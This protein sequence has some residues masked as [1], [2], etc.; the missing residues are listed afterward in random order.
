[1]N[2]TEVEAALL[3][4]AI[5]GLAGLSGGAFAA[6]ASIRASQAA[7]RA[8]LARLLH[9]LTVRII[10]LRVA[11]G[12]QRSVAMNNFEEA[13][14]E[15]SIHQR[16][17]CPSR[18]ISV[19]CDLLRREFKN[20]DLDADTTLRLAGQ[21]IERLGR[22]VGAHSVYL[23]RWR[24]SLFE[25]GIVQEWLKDPQSEVLS[26]SARSELGTLVRCHLTRHCS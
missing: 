17:L 9:L 4:A 13:F 18:R 6:L 2:F 8:P 22:M 20:P 3:G 19:M 16:I 21:A 5:G 14:N 1:M 26:A 12:D 24:T 15:F 25:I 11:P 23:F 10:A 7:T